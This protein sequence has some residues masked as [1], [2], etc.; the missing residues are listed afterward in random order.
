VAGGEVEGEKPDDDPDEPLDVVLH[1]IRR[2]L[3]ISVYHRFKQASFDDY[4]V[5]HIDG[6]LDAIGHVPTARD[7]DDELLMA[8]VFGHRM[9]VR[10][11][12]PCAC[13]MTIDCGPTE[14]GNLALLVDRLTEIGREDLQRCRRV[15]DR[16]ATRRVEHAA[17]TYD[18]EEL[19]R[20]VLRVLVKARHELPAKEIAKRLG[21]G[22]TGRQVGGALKVLDRLGLVEAT[23]YRYPKTGWTELQWRALDLERYYTPS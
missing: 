13:G 19:Q 22:P 14:T 1:G 21:D 17:G 5:G 11:K 23:E 9:L 3:R 12:Q 4:Y 15:I 16:T 2:D 20:R 7:P 10:Q 18:R 6:L 8:A